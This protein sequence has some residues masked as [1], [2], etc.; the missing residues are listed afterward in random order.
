MQAVMNELPASRRNSSKPPCSS[1][2]PPLSRDA[3]DVIR[4]PGEDRLDEQRMSSGRAI[5]QRPGRP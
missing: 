2:E 5:R 3:H 4:V 1:L